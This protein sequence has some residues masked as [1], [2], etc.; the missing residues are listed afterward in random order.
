MILRTFIFYEQYFIALISHRVSVF[1]NYTPGKDKT[2]YFA[3]FLFLG[4][5]PRSKQGRQNH[6]HEIPR[7]F[8][9]KFLGVSP[10]KVITWIYR[11]KCL[12]WSFSEE[13]KD[14]NYM[15]E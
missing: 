1:L 7:C 10:R 5:I 12:S 6:L 3:K 11:S 15:F 4:E 14:K 9:V 8:S 2:T 13:F